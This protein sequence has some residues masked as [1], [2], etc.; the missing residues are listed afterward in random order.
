MV[1]DS[2]VPVRPYVDPA[3]LAHLFKSRPQP[4]P[5]DMLSTH[6]SNRL[7]ACSAIWIL[8]R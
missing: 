1:H 2:P 5:A 6:R 4:P 7:P 3:T 8:T